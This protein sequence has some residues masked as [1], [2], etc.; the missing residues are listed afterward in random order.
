MAINYFD[1]GTAREED[2]RLLGKGMPPKPEDMLKQGIGDKN[3]PKPPAPVQPVTPTA[4]KTPEQVLEELAQLRSQGQVNALQQAIE[5]TRQG[6]A[7][8]RQAI[9]PLANEQRRQAGVQDTMNRQALANMRIQQGLSGSGAVGQDTIAQNVIQSGR[10]GA[11][12]TQEAQ[13]IADIERRAQTAEQDYQFAVANAKNAA[14]IEFAKLRYEAAKDA[15]AKLEAQKEQGFQRELATI[16][17]YADDYQA[18]IDRRMA[19]N[20]NDPI[21]PFLQ[22]ERQKKIAGQTADTR[23]QEL[24]TIGRYSAQPGGFMAEIQRRQ[25]TPTKDDDW[26]IPYLEV[27]RGGK[28]EAQQQAEAKARVEAQKAQEALYDDAIRAWN[29][30]VPLTVAQAQVLGQKP[31]A[32]KPKATSK[33]TTKPKPTP[34]PNSLGFLTE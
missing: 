11:I 3:V 32:T 22:A 12:D 15:E 34:D 26:L 1:I 27:A 7:Q 13:A 4:T 8:E 28:I 31:G 33:T 20:P 14:D 16:G 19:I 5:R 29:A 21:I 30:G 18:E 6:L 10:L 24:D 25:A 2:K 9:A 17:Q 23:Q